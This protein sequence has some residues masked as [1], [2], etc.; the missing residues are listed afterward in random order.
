MH[1]KN[2]FINSGMVS[3][4]GN[5]PMVWAKNRH[6][7]CGLSYYCGIYFHSSSIRYVG[8]QLH[9]HTRIIAGIYFCL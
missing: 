1:N 6:T 4:S 2:I 8:L 7:K 5:G 3:V 9:V